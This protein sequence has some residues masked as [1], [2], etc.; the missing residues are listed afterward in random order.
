MRP[1]HRAVSR[2]RTD[3]PVDGGG[4]GGVDWTVTA[5]HGAQAVAAPGVETGGALEAE[6]GDEAGDEEAGD[7]KQVLKQH[8]DKVLHSLARRGPR[9]FCTP[10]VIQAGPGVETGHGTRRQHGPGGN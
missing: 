9:R 10:G 8:S 6:A 3:T 5:A 1:G 7:V 4:G 2:L